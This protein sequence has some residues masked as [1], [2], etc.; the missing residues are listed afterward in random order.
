MDQPSNIEVLNMALEATA[1]ID[2]LRKSI[3]DNAESVLQKTVDVLNALD[4]TSGPAAALLI[5]LAASLTTTGNLLVVMQSLVESTPE[6]LDLNDQE[7]T[8]ESIIKQFGEGL[9]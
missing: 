4:L 1:A 3:I 8:F 9:K 5:S 6:Q 7:A 2:D